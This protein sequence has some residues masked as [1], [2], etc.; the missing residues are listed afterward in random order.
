MQQCRYTHSRERQSV[1]CSP[2]VCC[3]LGAHCLLLLD[4]L[5]PLTSE[6]RADVSCKQVARKGVW[7]DDWSRATD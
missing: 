7:R 4:S 2:L 5:L 1:Y 6:T 3:Y